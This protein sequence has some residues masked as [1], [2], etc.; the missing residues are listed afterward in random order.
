MKYEIKYV[1]A[2]KNSSFMFLFTELIK[3]EL[4]SL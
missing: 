1:N 2:E 4:N 3:E